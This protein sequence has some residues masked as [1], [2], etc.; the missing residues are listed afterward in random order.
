MDNTAIPQ[1]G[2]EQETRG[3]ALLISKAHTIGTSKGS[4]QVTPKYQT[5]GASNTTAT[6]ELNGED[7]GQV[8]GAAIDE[9]PQVEQILQVHLIHT[10]AME[11]VGDDEPAIRERVY[12]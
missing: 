4:D 7:Q 10:L 8:Q 11:D 1:G 12:K 3:K 5:V 6:M 2:R 9:A